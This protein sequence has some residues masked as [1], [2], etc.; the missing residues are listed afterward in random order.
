MLTFIRRISN[1]NCKPITYIAFILNGLPVGRASSPANEQ[2]GL[3]D[4]MDGST[5]ELERPIL[6]SALPI[7]RP[8]A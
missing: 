1:L 8:A 5:R 2:T 4:L 6:L 3:A 7:N